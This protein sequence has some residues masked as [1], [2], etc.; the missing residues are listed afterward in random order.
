[1]YCFQTVDPK[2][3]KLKSKIVKDQLN[4]LF[5]EYVKEEP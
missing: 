1:M 4:K 5:S 2:S 3:S